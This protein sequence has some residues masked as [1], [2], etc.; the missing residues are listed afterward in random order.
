MEASMLKDR[1]RLAGHVP[2]QAVQC[3]GRVDCIEVGTMPADDLQ[4]TVA[5]SRA[6]ELLVDGDRMGD[7]CRGV[8]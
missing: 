5:G 6:C 2:G 4:D 3:G 7:C 8:L 1:L